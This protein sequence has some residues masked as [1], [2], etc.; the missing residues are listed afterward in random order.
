MSKRSIRARFLAE[1]RSLSQPR[2][3]KLSRQIQQRFLDSELYAEARLLALYSAV[4][5]EVLTDMAGRHALD[6]GKRVAFP[7]VV[8]EHLEFVEIASLDDLAAGVYAVP[9]PVSGNRVPVAALDLV[10]VP[11]VVFDQTGHRLGYGR[12]YYDKALEECRQDCQK[13]GF[14]YDFQ[15]VDSLP[16]MEEHDRTLSVLMTEQRQ[17]NFTAR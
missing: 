13:V 10:V 14:A 16:I 12:G 3:D 4:H 2:R 6:A 17:L 1:R 5:N 9:E 8:G 7:R 15:V 11:G